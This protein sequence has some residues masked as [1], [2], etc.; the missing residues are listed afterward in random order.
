M[1]NTQPKYTGIVKIPTHVKK[2]IDFLHG[3]CK[4]NEWS[5]ILI[6]KKN[7][8]D[9]TKEED[10]E[11]EVMGIYPMNVGSHAYTEYEYGKH[12][13]EIY[14]LFDDIEV[15]KTGLIHSHHNMSAFFSGTD[16]DELKTNCKKHNLYL[17]LVVNFNE[18]YVAKIALPSKTS[19]VRS[20][21]L[22]DDYGNPITFSKTETESDIFIIDLDVEIEDVQFS[23]EPWFE[24]RFKEVK[25][26]ADKPKYVAPTAYGRGIGGATTGYGY[27]S[28]NYGYNDKYKQGT[29]D[30]DDFDNGPIYDKYGNKTQET[31]KY[32]SLPEPTKPYT[33]F[34]A[35]QSSKDIVK[36]EK[37]AVTFLTNLNGIVASSL[38]DTLIELSKIDYDSV[39]EIDILLATAGD[40]LA[41]TY[42][43]VFDEDTISPI[44][45][46]QVVDL[47]E[48]E[49]LRLESENRELKDTALLNDIKD[50]LFS[51]MVSIMDAQDEEGERIAQK[52]NLT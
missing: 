6:Y 1:S 52:L 41:D 22:L 38:E 43:I 15:V 32:R 8:G 23:V 16:M 49:E 27:G 11:F 33:A 46:E 17:S 50:I 48:E 14:D 34:D 36:L 21:E 45:L 26:E 31:A 51:Y 25:A 9:F 44:I 12:I 39:N 47:L 28:K 7:A 35:E 5:G 18:K 24:T 30:W 3:E 20:Y 37:F 40:L 29:F 13:A 4:N 42:K 2:Q 10:F 19:V